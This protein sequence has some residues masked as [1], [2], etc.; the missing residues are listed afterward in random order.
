MKLIR[1]NSP[2]CMF[3]STTKSYILRNLDLNWTPPLPQIEGYHQNSP[4]CRVF[5][6]WN[7]TIWGIDSPFSEKMRTI[8][9]L[10]CLNHVLQGIPAKHSFNSLLHFVAFIML[11]ILQTEESDTEV[12]I[13]NSSDWRKSN[14]I[15]HFACFWEKLNPTICRIWI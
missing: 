12:N 3:L 2:L 1:R 10:S 6:K 7:P 14:K 9:I 13:V 5:V 8:T 11:F 4:L 15:S